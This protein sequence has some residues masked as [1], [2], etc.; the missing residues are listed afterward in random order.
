MQIIHRVLRTGLIVCALAAASLAQGHES[1]PEFIESF[2]T[3][4]ELG[5]DGALAVSHAIDVHPHGD[6]IRRGLFFE[7]PES[8]GPLSDFSATLDG[9]PI[10]LEFDDGAVIVAAADQLATHQ[11]HRFVLRYRAHSPWWLESPETARL[12]WEP[13]ISQFELAW[14]DATLRIAWPD[15]LASMA[16]P[17]GGTVDGNTWTRSLR[18]PLH[19]EDADAPAEW[20]ELRAAP[21]ALS[22]PSL[23]HYGVD[24]PWRMLL[25]AGVLGLLGFL[26]LAWRAVGR[27]PELGTVAQRSEAPDGLSPAATRFVDQ[28]GFDESAFIAALLSLR[29]K[30]AVDFSIDEE[31]K[32]LRLERRRGARASLSPGERAMLDAL[33]DGRD[34]AQFSPGDEATGRALEALKKKLGEEHRG[35]HF[36]V[37][38][39]H[40]NWG[41]A[42]GV[43]L[44]ALAVVALVVQ[45]RDA[46]TPDPW[47]IG[48][49]F[50][51]LLVGIFAPLIYI[52][53]LKAPTRAGAAVKRQIAGLRRYFED[54]TTPVLDAGHFVAL[55]P[56]ATALDCETAWR[57]RFEGGNDAEMDG[58][59][60]EVLD[61]YREF[62]RN[63]A[64]TAVIVTIIAGA[65]IGSTSAAGGAG[66]GASAGG[67]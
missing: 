11:S 54:N 6:E 40:R 33:L 64:S 3:T 25:A 62:Q 32:V 34:S 49:G 38:A 56:Y 59:V 28:M 21:A 15:A 31:D 66:G 10:E 46:L 60:A 14:R 52:D 61:W 4:L 39:F 9:E 57:E 30:Q 36:V 16:L 27:D 51:A 48:L 45:A 29:V 2:D 7:L 18:G 58:D 63:H 50:A 41:I 67:V 22:A 53:L 20:I 42:L 37:N 8:L 13:V 26:H 1:G 23:R 43:A 24:W 12:R 19:G 65:S 55:L 17:A 35:R 44:I 5:D 47:A